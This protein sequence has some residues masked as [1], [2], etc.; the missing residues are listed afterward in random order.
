MK[1]VIQQ[2]F[3]CPICR[4]RLFDVIAENSI[5]TEL[6]YNYGIIIKRWKCSSK[7]KIINKD[8]VQAPLKTNA[9]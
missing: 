2:K 5:S 1:K 3:R 4:G 8:L 6:V 9:E 7:I